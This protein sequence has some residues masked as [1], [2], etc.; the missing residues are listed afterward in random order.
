VLAALPSKTMVLG[1]LDLGSPQAESP[2]VVARRI[3]AALKHLPASR[4]VLAPDCGMK[5]LPRA[6]A[7]AKLAA[8]VAGARLADGAV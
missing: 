7:R 5:H 8:M 3:E 4:L 6:L 2:D 1:V